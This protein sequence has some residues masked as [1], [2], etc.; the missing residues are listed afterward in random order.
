M[1]DAETDVCML[2]CEL[3]IACSWAWEETER[4]GEQEAARHVHTVRQCDT[5]MLLSS[6]YSSVIQVYAIV[7]TVQQCDSGMLLSSQYSSVIQVYAI[8]F[9]TFSNFIWN[10]LIQVVERVVTSVYFTLPS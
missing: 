3:V 4:D 1:S 6:Q 5:G 9:T 8:V 10:D 2:C 7:F